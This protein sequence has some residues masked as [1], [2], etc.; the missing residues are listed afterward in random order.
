VL[1]AKYDNSLIDGGFV[2]EELHPTFLELRL[3]I[4]AVGTQDTHGLGSVILDIVN[5]VINAGVPTSPGEALP[6]INRFT[7]LRKK[8]AN[9]KQVITE[10]LKSLLDPTLEYEMELGDVIEV[11]YHCELNLTPFDYGNIYRNIRK[12]LRSGPIR[13]YCVEK[14]LTRYL[15]GKYQRVSDNYYMERTRGTVY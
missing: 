2:P 10:L 1:P 14:G 5:D 6:F 9:M 7:G 4:L 15:N 8:K 11:C 12:Q 3:G 13:D